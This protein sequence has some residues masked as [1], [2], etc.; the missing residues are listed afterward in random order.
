MLLVLIAFYPELE[1]KLCHWIIQQRSEELTVNQKDIRVQALQLAKYEP[2]A[3]EQKFNASN[4]WIRR[5]IG[6]SIKDLIIPGI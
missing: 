1:I 5:F 4:G 2:K 6:L 3:I